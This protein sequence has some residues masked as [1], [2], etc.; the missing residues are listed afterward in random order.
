[1][2]GNQGGGV[3]SRLDIKR[4]KKI[5]LAL[6]VILFFIG[7][8]WADELIVPFICDP[9]IIQA[10]FM[11]HGYILDLPGERK[12][13]LS[14][15]FLEN[16]GNEYIIHTYNSITSKELEIVQQIIMEKDDVQ[17]RG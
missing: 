13:P 3:I 10:K 6:S 16:K 15:G 12:T 14:W 1:M 17:D 2:K 9:E 5:F 11:Q 4:M 8:A 7:I